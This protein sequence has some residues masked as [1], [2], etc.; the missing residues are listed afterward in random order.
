MPRA[1]PRLGRGI[2]AYSLTWTSPATGWSPHRPWCTQQCLG[3][4][5]STEL[6]SEAGP[7]KSQSLLTVVF[8]LFMIGFITSQGPAHR[9][10]TSTTIR[11][12]K[13]Q[14]YINKE[15]KSKPGTFLR[16]FQSSI[17]LITRSSEL[18]FFLIPIWREAV[19][20][21]Q[22]TVARTDFRAQNCSSGDNFSVLCPDT[23][24]G[25]IIFEENF[26]LWLI[27]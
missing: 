12:E 3:L 6:I 5:S 24:F 4:R 26:N 19:A 9:V 14:E 15:N 22:K 7:H 18:S 21:W 27:I 20:R 25:R 2:L 8:T 23:Y 17:S 10:Y 16:F 1:L 11:P 13:D